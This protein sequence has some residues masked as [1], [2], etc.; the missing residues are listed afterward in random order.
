MALRRGSA[1]WLS[2]GAGARAQ[3]GTGLPV[4]ELMFVGQAVALEAVEELKSL[5]LILKARWA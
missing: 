4:A 5:A 1:P 2:P 3:Q